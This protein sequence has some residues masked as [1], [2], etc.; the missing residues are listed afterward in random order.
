MYVAGLSVGGIHHNTIV[1]AT[2]HNSIYAFDADSSGCA[3]LWQVNLVGAGETTIPAA[4]IANCYDILGEFGVTGTPVID[5][6]SLTLY[7]VAASKGGTNYFQRLHAIDLTTGAERSGSPATINATVTQYSGATISFNALLQNQRPALALTNGGV[8]VGWS[9]H[10]DKGQYWGWLMRYDATSLA[11]TAVFNV[12]PNGNYGGIW[13]SGGAPAAHNSGALFLSTGNGSFDDTVSS[14][15][16]ILPNNDFSMSFLSLNPTSLAVQDFYTPSSEATWSTSD[17]D[18][19]SGGVTVLPDGR[20]PSAHPNLLVGGDKQGNLWLLDRSSLGRFSATTNNVV[21]MLTLPG[22]SICTGECMYSTPA[23]YA[24]SVYLANSVS[25]LL[26]LPLTGGIFSANA[27]NMPVASSTSTETYQ[28]PGPTP[29]ISAAPS[30]GALIW[31]LDTS[32]YATSLGSGGPAVLRA[33]GVTNL[34]STLYSS[35]SLSNHTAG[36]A[37]KFSVPVVANGHVYVGGTRQ[38]TVYGLSP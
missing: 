33:Y 25:Q 36:N 16:P 21:Q 15:P 35:D 10:C 3:I 28:F 6:A 18:I 13:M 5:P 17:L 12:A 1:V 29:S 32:A 34:N 9:G 24:G 19:S 37:V 7:V 23:Y 20:G 38:L 4:D 31:V 14:L 26:E 27:Q 30:S 11:Q 8:V 22:S 2:Q